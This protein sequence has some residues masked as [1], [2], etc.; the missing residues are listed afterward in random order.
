MISLAKS[1]LFKIFAST[2]QSL[3]QAL[4]ASLCVLADREDPGCE[5]I[6]SAIAKTRL[7]H[8]QPTDSIVDGPLMKII[9]RLIQ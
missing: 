7:R 4:L 5:W 3:I 6:D 2:K 8:H 9:R 1:L